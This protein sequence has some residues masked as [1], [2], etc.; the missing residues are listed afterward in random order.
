MGGHPPHR[1]RAH[2][3]GRT[4]HAYLYPVSTGPAGYPGIVGPLGVL[5]ATSAAIEFDD[6]TGHGR[7]QIMVGRAIGR[8]NPSSFI[9]LPPGLR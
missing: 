2:D 7:T 6:P 9:K 8:A 5:R 1:A 4:C 3:G